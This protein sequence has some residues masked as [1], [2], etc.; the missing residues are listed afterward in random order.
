MLMMRGFLFF[1]LLRLFDFFRPKE[2]L[3]LAG[4]CDSNSGSGSTDS[5]SSSMNTNSSSI[6]SSMDSNSSNSSSSSISVNTTT[7]SLHSDSLINTNYNHH[8][9][10]RNFSDD[11]LEPRTLEDLVFEDPLLDSS[12]QVQH[13]DSEM[14]QVGNKLYVEHDE[15]R[16]ISQ[17][18]QV[19][20]DEQVEYDH[21]QLLQDDHDQL[22]LL[23]ENEENVDYHTMQTR[24]SESLLKNYCFTAEDIALDGWY[25]SGNEPLSEDCSDGEEEDEAEEA[26]EAEDGE[27]QI[28]PDDYC[29]NDDIVVVDEQKLQVKRCID[30][31]TS[32]SVVHGGVGEEETESDES[33]PISE[34]SNATAVYTG[35][36]LGEV[37]PIDPVQLAF[38]T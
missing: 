18:D 37:L 20:D 9:T 27:G 21:E 25:Y 35:P 38:L 24:R 33:N 1:L 6:N 10:H 31:G 17:A 7:S 28:M 30:E 22:L 14:S 13:S 23:D 8:H 11:L 5:N 12:I 4:A 32:I 15:L 34:E 19:D 26:E 36:V 2:P 16:Q 3:M 29:D